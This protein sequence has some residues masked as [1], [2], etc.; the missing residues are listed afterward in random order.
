MD[1]QPAPAYLQADEIIDFD[2]PEVAALAV[3]LAQGA[4]DEITLARI[5]FEWVRDEIRHSFDEPYEPE[6]AVSCTASEVLMQGHGICYAKSHLLAALLRANG[7]AAGFDYQRLAD[8][9]LGGFC[10][11]GVNTI[12]LPGHGWYRVDPRGNKAEVD[13]QF[14][15]PKETLAFTHSAPGE[16][17]YGLNLHTPLPEVVKSLKQAKS[18]AAL[19]QSLPRNVKM[20]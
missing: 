9:G 18:V 14:I 19:S 8:D 6:A 3:R 2:H 15:P 11:H 20:G 10:L 12:Y 16:I 7:I 13:A 17:D 5:C 1:T 4:K